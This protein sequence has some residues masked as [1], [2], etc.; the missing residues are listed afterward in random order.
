MNNIDNKF[1]IIDD[2]GVIYAGYSEEETRELFE[3]ISTGEF[4]GDFDL[5][6]DGDVDPFYDG[7]FEGDL[8]LIEV[9]ALHN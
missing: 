1:E 6:V 4:N 2:K 7:S 8:K 3:K 5:D 9:H